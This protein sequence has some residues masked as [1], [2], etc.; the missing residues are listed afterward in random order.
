MRP[1][2]VEPGQR[3][4]RWTVLRVSRVSGRGNQT[5]AR[6]LCDCGTEREL[7]ALKLRRS[8]KP[9][10][11]CGCAH[12]KVTNLRHG[13]SA[14]KL[15][16]GQRRETPEYSTWCA[17]NERCRSSN[18]DYGGRGIKVCDRWS[19]PGGFENF[20]ADMGLRPN[21]TSIDRINNDGNY[22]PS[23]C[24]WATNS[25]QSQNT[26]AT[27]L[28]PGMVNE[29]R[30]RSEHGE[31]ARALAKRFGVSYRAASDVIARRTWRNVP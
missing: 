6:C 26:R 7:N 28:T 20:L 15:P 30:G 31:T 12:D 27:K 17:L 8:T 21:G 29:M 9:S 4:G 23:N 22:E 18:K 24:R 11:S 14:G 19:G 13:H 10:R 25:E 3:Y 1:I 2:L 16:N 5:W